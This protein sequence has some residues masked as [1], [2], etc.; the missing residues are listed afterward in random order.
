LKT[1]FIIYAKKIFFPKLKSL[2]TING[3]L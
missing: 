1:F 3:K 2:V